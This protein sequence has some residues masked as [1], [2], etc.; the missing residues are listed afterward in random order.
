MTIS[1]CLHGAVFLVPG[2][3]LAPP[4]EPDPKGE[5]YVEIALEETWDWQ[6]EAIQDLVFNEMPETQMFKPVQETRAALSF[7]SQ[8]D[9]ITFPV[10]DLDIPEPEDAQEISSAETLEEILKDEPPVEQPPEEPVEQE[11][12]TMPP[13]PEPTPPKPEMVGLLDG[14]ILDQEN[15]LEVPYPQMARRRGQ[16]GAVTVH[17]EVS[18][19]GLVQNVTIKQSSGHSLLDS[20]VLRAVKRHQYQPL[21]QNGRAVAAQFDYKVQFVLK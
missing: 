20:A 3:F 15:P 17:I 19:Q 6:D 7:P 18:P 5:M 14:S 2:D 10:P 4:P 11:Q 9:E 1:L 16:E 13:P 12:A 21:I 8:I